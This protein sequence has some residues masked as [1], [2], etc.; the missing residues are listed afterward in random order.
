MFVKEANQQDKISCLSLR[1][2]AKINLFLKILN[3]RPDGYHEI[4]SLMQKIDLFDN[5][6]FSKQGAT[7]SLSCPDT[8]LPEDEGNLVYRAAQAFFTATGIKAGIKIVLEKK[9]PLAAGLGGGSSDAAAV[10]IALNRLFNTGLDRKRLSEIARP[11]GADVEFFV[12]DCSAAL[13]T[14]IGD[15]IQK[16][17]PLAGFTI[18]LVNPGFGVST[19]WVYENFPLTSSS[20]PYILARDRNMGK[21]LQ[22]SFPG[23]IEK[24]GNDLEA[25][26]IKRY[27]E[28]AAIKKE[29]K[30]AGAA[31]SL[32]SGSG[33]TVFGLFLTEDDAQ[34]S[35]KQ[36]SKKYRPNL[37]LARPHIP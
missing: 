20:N 32:M 19:K 2:P 31:A 16:V 13:A 24:L 14:G 15:R 37:F 28:I 7:I 6:H 22:D 34:R 11:L 35:F 26:T 29:L 4:E 33:P 23:F 12:Q 25:V 9:I 3:R 30:M 5:L 8:P 27:P 21:M 1:A 18:L 36:L 10:V 17:D